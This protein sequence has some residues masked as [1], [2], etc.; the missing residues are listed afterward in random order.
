METVLPNLG[1]SV[2]F[3]LVGLVLLFLGYSAIDMLTPGDMHKRIF[4]EANIA[5]GILAAAFVVGLAMIIA[6][7]IS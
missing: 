4:E 5:V 1:L 7:A 3:A 2:L 6:S